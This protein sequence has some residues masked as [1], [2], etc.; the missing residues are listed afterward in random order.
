MLSR[1]IISTIIVCL[2][3]EAIQC[4]PVSH[5][6]NSSQD[7]ITLNSLTTEKADSASWLKSVTPVLGR[8]GWCV[9]EKRQRWIEIGQLGSQQTELGL[10][11]SGKFAC[12]RPNETSDMVYCCGPVRE[13]HCCRLQDTPGLKWGVAVGVVVTLIVFLTVSYTIQVFRVC[14]RCYHECPI[15][16]FGAD[17]TEFQLNTRWYTVSHE[18]NRYGVT[19]HSRGFANQFMQRLEERYG[20]WNTANIL[21][22]QRDG[23]DF[24]I[25]SIFFH[26]LFTPWFYTQGPIKN[27]EE[28]IRTDFKSICQTVK[29]NLRVTLWG[30]SWRSCSTENDPNEGNLRNED[31]QLGTNKPESSDK[32]GRVPSRLA[33][34]WVP[35]TKAIYLPPTSNQS[36]G[37]E[38]PQQ[39]Q[40]SCSRSFRR[41]STR[42]NPFRRSVKRESLQPIHNTVL[43]EAIV[44]CN[45]LEKGVQTRQTCMKTKRGEL[46]YPI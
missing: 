20:R 43:E 18:G 33:R 19:F 36:T 41:T 24:V 16:G 3:S 17:E 42:Y 38:S 45:G 29:A 44:E 32:L 4:I 30:P 12:P 13:Q 11:Q 23:Q 14:D 6:Q 37:T 39:S 31:L 2:Q 35:W 34:R 46:I 40:A 1:S 8:V 26:D 9:N 21:K 15:V 27:D 22:I 25:L 7:V 28:W 10:I 5:S